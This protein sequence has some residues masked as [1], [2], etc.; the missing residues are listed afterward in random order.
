MKLITRKSECIKAEKSL[1]VK[2]PKEAIRR[3]LNNYWVVDGVIID[4]YQ[5]SYISKQE[6]VLVAAEY[7][8]NFTIKFENNI[9]FTN[10]A[11]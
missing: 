1:L 10:T 11:N 7:S 4:V 2:S 9:S 8:N 5:P 6:A 3:T